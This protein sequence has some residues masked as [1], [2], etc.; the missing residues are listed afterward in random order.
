MPYLVS[1]GET[2]NLKQWYTK[3]ALALLIGL[4][5]PGMWLAYM[6]QQYGAHTVNYL[7]FTQIS[8]RI[9]L[10]SNYGNQF[11]NLLKG[12]LPWSIAIFLLLEKNIRSKFIENKHL[13]LLLILFGQLLFFSY[14]VKMQSPHYLIPL[15]L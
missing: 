3:I 4:L 7:L 1:P 14:L 10:I 5:I 15:F 8:K 11:E 9:D 13:L 12:I 2:V 6:Y